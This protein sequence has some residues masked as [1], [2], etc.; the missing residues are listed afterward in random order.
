[1][2]CGSNYNDI[3]AFFFV[4]V[5]AEPN[6]TIPLLDKHMDQKGDMTWTCEA[7]GIPDVTYSW[8]RNG[9]PLH[10]D[11]LNLEDRNRYHMQDNVLTIRY[12]D[13]ERDQAMYQCQAKNQ[14]KTRY[15]SAQLRVLCMLNM[16]LFCE[17]SLFVAK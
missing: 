5:S 8:F 14:L 11:H 3:T 12:L 2:W 4:F 17:V 1:V 9:E 6:F 13:P 10:P 16:S 15:S 7:F